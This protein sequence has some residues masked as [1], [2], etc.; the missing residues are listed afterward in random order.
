M[1]PVNRD[2]MSG[3]AFGRRLA[4]AFGFLGL[5][6]CAP[7]A[8]PT[9]P[10]TPL[11]TSDV[12]VD[13]ASSPAS[14]FYHPTKP[15]P[16]RARLGLDDGRTLFAG[17]RGERWLFDGKR[18]QVE[19]A[20]RLAPET[21]IA[22]SKMPSGAWLFVGQSGTGY[23]AAAPLAPFVRSSAPVDPL[24]RVAAS[25]STI[26]GIRFDGALV[27][28]ENAG[29]SWREIRKPGANFV[30]V[31]IAD[32]KTGVAFAV[33][34]AWIAT[35]DHGKTWHPLDTPG[36]GA[37]ALAKDPERGIVALGAISWFDVALNTPSPFAP[38][39]SGPSEEGYAI[40]ASLPR[41][42]NASALLAG[43]A[44][45][46]GDR[47][48]ELARATHGE[49]S[50]WSGA[51]GQPL[52]EKVLQSAKGCGDVRLAGFEQAVYFACFRSPQDEQAGTVELYR[53]VNG[54]KSFVLEPY[55][56]ESKLSEF[57]MAVGKGAELLVTGICP[58]QDSDRGCAAHG[59]YHRKKGKKVALA[60]SAL[61]GLHQV[62]LAMT[63]AQGGQIA[64]VVGRRLKERSYTLFVST[65]RGRRFLARDIEQLPSPPPER[66]DRPWYRA[67]KSTTVRAS[68]SAG[69]D[70]T[71]AL[72]FQHDERVMLA[73]TDEDGRVLSLTEG[74]GDASLIGAYGTYGLAVAPKSRAV[75]E[76]MD[77][78]VSW[79]PVGLAP[80]ELCQEGK[81]CKV[82]ISCGRAGCVVGDE[83]TRVGWRGQ[84]DLETGLSGP[85]G[86]LEKALL[87]PRVK[88]PLS[89]TLADEEWQRLE[90]VRD[91]P[92]AFEAAIG[93]TVWHAAGYD[94]ENATAWVYH[95]LSGAKAKVE[96]K[97]LFGPVKNPKEYAF[98]IFDQVE[99]SSAL[100][101]QVPSIARGE[102]Q[103]QNVEVA[104]DNRFE[105][106]VKT[107]RLGRRFIFSP[108]DYAAGEG[109][110]SAARPDLV[111]IG[112]GGVY[113][114]LHH[115]QADEQATYFLDGKRVDEIPP[116]NWP[117]APVSG[118]TEM[119]H[120]GQAHLPIKL[121]AN[122]AALTRATRSGNRWS[123]ESMAIGMAKPSDFGF[124][125]QTGITYVDGKS[126]FYA[127]SF[128]K[129][130]SPRSGWAFP[131]EPTGAISKQPVPIPQQLD[132]PDSPLP[133][134]EASRKGTPRIVAPYQPG[135]R[136]PIIISHK[137]E[138][139]RTLLS[140]DAVLYGTP[141]APC[142]AALAA[143][144]VDMER[145]DDRVW[146]HAIVDPRALDKAWAFRVVFDDAGGKQVSYR[147]MSC[148][149]DPQAEV[150]QLVFREP[151]TL[152]NE[153]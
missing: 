19:A 81:E 146:M 125:Q 105:D 88:T 58:P 52:K 26:A 48:V 115:T 141:K 142:L 61:P 62:P 6:A 89:C 56:V 50:M 80:A 12:V 29:V 120:A 13:D 152:A 28:T 82:P 5:V 16:L 36:I 15:A 94:R 114:R 41:G 128:A 30:D 134:D 79:Q 84:A 63:F 98:A 24:K 86:S 99:G 122:G 74:P 72:V 76:T 67:R 109:G 53:S 3:G 127:L 117:A 150:P 17:E 20:A 70:G 57:A 23:E 69:D 119:I 96:R 111:S 59:V 68:L 83:L 123:F 108:G 101:Y 126:A 66:E 54:G 60:Q 124:T 44:A 133:C 87:Y 39:Q 148:V 135:T 104:W 149:F 9:K 51:L 97:P 100:R 91:Q 144:A 92:S 107:V 143:E 145:R 42:P 8:A 110:V 4:A 55:E 90:G 31:Q 75:W 121:V 18:D 11:I 103:I 77:G 137:I 93:S 95:G 129:A 10:R 73:V 49:W 1:S 2:R 40:E 140:T 46:L 35:T 106:V 138:P 37:L 147:R 102:H 33:P 116:V 47:Y 78:G 130:G 118:R 65:D 25:G 71:L 113:L 22:I 136:H 64:Y 131:V 32:D 45:M 34:E 38:R 7:N 139:I 43:R 14:W 153:P 151:G 85:P 112:V 27:H 21:L 132:L